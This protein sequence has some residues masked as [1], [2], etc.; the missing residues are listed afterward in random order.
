MAT[1]LKLSLLENG[2]SDLSVER[3]DARD[4]GSQVYDEDAAEDMGDSN[5]PDAGVPEESL[6][7]WGHYGDLSV[8]F[9]LVMQNLSNFTGLINGKDAESENITWHFGNP[10]D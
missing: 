1:G 3:D 6:E 10:E 2:T 8:A 9:P 4:E 5:P 7:T